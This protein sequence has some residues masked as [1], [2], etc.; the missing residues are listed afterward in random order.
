MPRTKC[1][2]CGADI[3]ISE[4]H[5]DEGAEV[6]CSDECDHI[7]RHPKPTPQLWALWV[8]RV[9]VGWW[10]E[11]RGYDNFADITGA[12]EEF[13]KIHAAPVSEGKVGIAILPT[14]MAPCRENIIPQGV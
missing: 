11:E 7:Q 12:A 10:L 1:N 6:Y 3:Y 14:G 9:N 13:L 2:A 4:K 8:Y 5:R